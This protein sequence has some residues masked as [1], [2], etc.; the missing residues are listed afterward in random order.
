[1]KGVLRPCRWTELTHGNCW[2]SYTILSLI[3]GSLRTLHTRY[4]RVIAVVS[5]PA[6]MYAV[7]SS[8]ISLKVNVSSSSPLK[9][10]VKRVGTGRSGFFSTRFW[11]RRRLSVVYLRFFWM[12]SVLS[13]NPGMGNPFR[14]NFASH[15]KVFLLALTP[16]IFS[17]FRL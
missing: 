16:A 1:M 2:T 17:R 11:Y 3:S 8:M 9:S 13:P 4:E 12:T 6:T 14:A 15:G 7:A 10:L 5:L